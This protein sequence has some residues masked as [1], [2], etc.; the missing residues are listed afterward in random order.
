[1]L[2]GAGA[3]SGCKNSSGDLPM[4][5]E[6]SR[7]LLIE[8]GIEVGEG[9]PLPRAYRAAVNEIGA[10]RVFQFLQ[11]RFS[12]VT[13]TKT[14]QLIPTVS[15]ECIWTLNIDD[16]VEAGFAECEAPSQRSRSLNWNSNPRP[17]AGTTNELPIV[18]LHGYVGAP[19]TADTA[20]L[21]FSIDEYIRSL[22]EASA[23][24]WQTRLRGDFP[25]TPIIAVGSRLVDEIDFFETI[26]LGNT[27]GKWK[28][29]SFLVVPS[30]NDFDRREI[31]GL[32][33]TIIE[34]TS[35]EFFELVCESL[36]ERHPTGEIDGKFTSKFTERTFHPLPVLVSEI[37]RS[38]A[39]QFFDGVDPIWSDIVSDLDAI[40]RWANS[41][42]EEIGEANSRRNPFLFLI[43]GEPFT[44]KSTALLRLA[45][46][47][48]SAGWEPVEVVGGDR[49]DVTETIEYLKDRPRCVLIFDQLAQ[50]ASEISQ[51][52]SVAKGEK[53]NFVMLGAERSSRSKHLKNVLPVRNVAGLI[54]PV[55]Q[56]PSEELWWQI[57]EKRRPFGRLGTMDGVRQREAKLFFVQ[58]ERNLYSALATLEDGRGFVDRGIEAFS[59]LDSNIQ[60]A[61]VA[62]ALIGQNGLWAPL[63]VVAA[64]SHLS[65]AQ[66]MAEIQDEG[67]LADW[68]STDVRRTGF[69]RLRQRYLGDLILK[70]EVG[71]GTRSNQAVI[72]FEICKVLGPRL[73]VEDI[74]RKTVESRIASELLDEKF[75]SQIY[76]GNDVDDWYQGLVNEFGWNARYW[77]QRALASRQ[78]G[79]AF[80]FA[81]R[82]VGLLRDSYS[83]NTL[84][85]V[86]MR[87]AVADEVSLDDRKRYW[88]EAV[89][90]LADAI[91]VQRGTREY[92]FI[93]FFAYTARL[94][95]IPEIYSCEWFSDLQTTFEDWYS[96]CLDGGLLEDPQFDS[97]LGHFPLAWRK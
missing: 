1:L 24:N 29:P 41:V 87:R 82:A 65:A 31:E 60:R 22:A 77:E 96:I 79:R 72:A 45:K 67:S 14:H 28:W 25:F 8:S 38:T 4:A 94:I 44:G 18:H 15:W 46:E 37:D 90:A 43:L 11:S 58:H 69:V 86:L 85:T 7:L 83:L 51:I 91:E 27:S 63:S 40:P 35:D 78:L 6:L 61:F 34:A 10:V 74:R 68:L 75:I 76:S 49:L 73:G 81:K 17:Y 9:I 92:P 3:S 50:D 70:R 12:N 48:Q 80:S 97:V 93:T 47:L 71:E 19:E 42:V 57:L 5:V 56:P 52:I 66:L 84:G 16:A 95:E 33:F 39:D 20:K 26:H 23:S 64:V 89:L 55:F 21:V 53:V 36:Q 54:T 32:G 59:S 30:I 88:N 13:P 62:I 2:L